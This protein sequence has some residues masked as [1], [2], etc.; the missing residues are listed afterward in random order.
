[1]AYRRR[2]GTARPSIFK[3][4]FGSPLLRPP[5]PPDNSSSSSSASSLAAKAIRASSAHRDSSLSSAYG[6]SAI[7]PSG[8]AN[9]ARSSPPSESKVR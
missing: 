8:E 5:P 9:L 3:E 7:P 4:E 2:Q 1:M 6:Q